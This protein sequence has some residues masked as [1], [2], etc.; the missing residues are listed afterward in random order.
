MIKEKIG[1]L[2][3]GWI[4]KNYADN[5]ESRGYEVV[6][7]SKDKEYV[8]NKDNLSDC[9]IIFVA[10][11]TPTID[12]N[13]DGSILKDAIGASKAGDTVVIKSTLIPEF[14]RE[15]QTAYPDRF[16]L[17]SPEFLSE[18][19]ARYDT[20]NPSRN[21]IGIS[22]IENKDL[23]SKAKDVLGILPEANI[24][25]VCTYEEA[26]LIKYAGNCFLYVKN[27]FFNMLYDLVNAYGCSW[28]DVRHGVINDPRIGEAYTDIFHKE[29]RGA[30]GHC[31]PKD[32]VAFRKMYFKHVGTD[33]VD[34]CNILV[35]NENKNKKL[36][37]KS[38]K[39]LDILSEVYGKG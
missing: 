6:R 35:Q 19:T 15:L 33:D 27:M 36:L 12:A 8:G 32:F 5:F 24:D 4:G 10:V 28:E 1:F 16:I 25:M 23:I 9:R 13:F 37:K 29:G 34:G 39:D 21:I 11:P 26:S 30:G 20:D 38:K 22:D 14:T 18:S 17:I 7:Y 3:Q 2:G 31:L